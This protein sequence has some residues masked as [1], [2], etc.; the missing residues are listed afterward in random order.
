MQGYID[1]EV[2]LNSEGSCY[3]SC[4]DYTLTKNYGCFDGT[5]CHL[6]GS[7]ERCNGTIY[8]CA[9]VETPLNICSVI[10]G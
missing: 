2:N 10:N 3:N 1:N 8:S 6:S 9:Y 5:M 7:K 4:S